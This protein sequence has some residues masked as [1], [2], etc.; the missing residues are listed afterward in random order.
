M[1]YCSEVPTWLVAGRGRRLPEPLVHH[2][3]HPRGRRARAVAGRTPSPMPLALFG[4]RG[5]SRRA[6]SDATRCRACSTPSAPWPTNWSSPSPDVTRG[7]AVMTWPS[8]RLCRRGVS[9]SDTAP[10]EVRG[11]SG[12]RRAQRWP[13]RVRLEVGGVGEAGRRGARSVVGTRPTVTLQVG[14][15]RGAPWNGSPGAAPMPW[16]ASVSSAERS[17]RHAHPEVDAVGAGR[18]ARRARRASSNEAIARRPERVLVAG[19]QRRRRWW[20]GGRASAAARPAGCGCSTR[21][22]SRRRFDDR[23]SPRR[24]HRRRPPGA[25]RGRGSWSS[26]GCAP[27]EPGR[28]CAE[29][30]QLAA[31][32][33]ARVVVLDDHRALRALLADV[34]LEQ[35]GERLRP[36]ARHRH[37]G[38]VVGAGLAEHRHRTAVEAAA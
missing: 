31:R 23:R 19:V 11:V 16:A 3:G 14:V 2:H 12:V 5:G 26:C 13:E 9:Q 27:C 30:H 28:N 8:V 32:D 15:R 33:V 22:P 21:D 35:F 25:D 38:R 4:S 10:S 18:T 7:S 37:P 1:G 29:A 24:P 36:A 34:L 20:V 17:S 6:W